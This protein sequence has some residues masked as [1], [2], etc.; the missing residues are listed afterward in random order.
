MPTPPPDTPGTC[1]HP[2]VTKGANQHGTWKKCSLCKAKLE[3]RPY[4]RNNPPPA[5]RKAQA[6][7]AEMKGYVATGTLPAPMV[8]QAA[9][10]SEAV[11]R[12]ELQRA[13]E[14]QAQQIA[15][16]TSASMAQAMAPMVEGM[17]HLMEQQVELPHSMV[18]RQ[19]DEYPANL[20]PRL[21]L[22]EL[23]NMIALGLQEQH[24]QQMED[25]DDDDE[26]SHWSRVQR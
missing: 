14:D 26:G 19:A 4:S 5:A 13:L 17:R 16:A 8:E 18:Q 20:F 11:H 24:S 3:Y 23:Q 6:K 25:E 21:N 15:Q 10:S 12:H 1:N 9:S 7:E 2:F 22:A